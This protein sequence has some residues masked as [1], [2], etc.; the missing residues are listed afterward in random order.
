[1]FRRIEDFN[2]DYLAVISVINDQT[3]KPSLSSSLSATGLS[4]NNR[5]KVSVSAS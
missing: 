3:T 4:L 5:F 2:G 1:M